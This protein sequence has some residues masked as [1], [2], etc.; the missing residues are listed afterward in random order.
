MSTN[1]DNFWHKDGK[2]AIIMRGSLIYLTTTLVT[3]LNVDA[4]NCYTCITNS[5]EGTTWFN[6]FVELNILHWK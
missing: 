6:K 4:P 1:F 3:V 2:E 5:T